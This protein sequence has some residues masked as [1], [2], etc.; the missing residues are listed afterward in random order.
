ML[1]LPFNGGGGLAADI[2]GHPVYALDLIDNSGGD[3]GQQLIREMRPVSGHEIIGF[4]G[5]NGYHIFVS[6]AISHHANG[7]HR[8]KDRES[9]PGVVHPIVLW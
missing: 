6:P 2:V 7:L 3:L 8:Q 4:H 5:A 9:R 1:L